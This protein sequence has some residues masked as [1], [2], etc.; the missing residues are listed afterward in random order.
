MKS[1]E[2]ISELHC[3]EQFN[4]GNDVLDDWLKRKAIKNETSHD[5]RTYVICEAQNVV[6]YYSIATGS[7]DHA[8]LPSS[9]KRNA[10]NP[11]S[12]MIL[13][14]LAIDVNWQKRGLGKDLLRDAI[15]K[16]MAISELAGVKALVVHAISSEAK[17][18]Y[19]EN[20]FIVSP[21]EMALI[22]PVKDILKNI[23]H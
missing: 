19:L 1:P 13:G 20:D 3:L 11:I 2:R 23:K 21:V 16:T 9:L 5:T 22:L 17:R 18:F 6:G 15:L 14:R 4:C 10:P 7:I 8:E 12:V